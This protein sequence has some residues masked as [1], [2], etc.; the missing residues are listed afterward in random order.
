MGPMVVVP[1]LGR[2]V[3]V[4]EEVVREEVV[5]GDEE[6]GRTS[7]GV[8]RSQWRIDP[9][10]PPEVRRGCTGCHAMAEMILIVFLL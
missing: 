6:V 3:L 10:D 4:V 2:A 9:S 1:P 7:S 8:E 5:N